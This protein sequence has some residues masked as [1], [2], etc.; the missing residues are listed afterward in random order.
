MKQWW[1]ENT[2][3]FDKKKLFLKVW[4]WIFLFIIFVIFF[5][6]FSFLHDTVQAWKEN[7]IKKIE[8]NNFIEVAFKNNISSYILKLIKDY[9]Q[10]KNVLKEDKFAFLFIE[11]NVQFFLDLLWYG[12]YAD[13]IIYIYKQFKPYKEE[14]FK[15][16]WEDKQKNYLIIFENIWEERPDSWF[17][18]SFAKVS[19]S[20]AHIVDFKIYDSYYL[21]WKY[22][23]TSWN[24]WFDKC[25]NKEELSLKNEIHIFNDLFSTTT[26]LT[27]NIYWFT[28]LNAE[29]IIRHYNQV[30]PEKINWVIF[31]KSSILEYLIPAWKE[32]IRNMEVLNSIKKYSWKYEYNE[33]LKW[34]WWAKTS[35]L[36]YINSFDRKSLI[37]QIIKNYKKITLNWQIR[38]YLSWI[39]VD[40]ENYLK[41]KNL[42]FYKKPYYWYLFFYNLWFNKI[43]KFVDHIV[44]VDDKVYINPDWFLLSKWK[45]IIKYLNLLNIDE[46]YYSFLKEKKISK[47]SYLYD[48]KMNYKTILIV[49]ENCKKESENI[50][51]YV[52]YCE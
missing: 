37:L 49:P 10:W 26:F 23:W 2:K 9:K 34:L 35:Y 18:W 19:F 15:L 40:F 31:F 29:N 51:N 12:D 17:F 11:E 14:I 33:T 36:E 25:K 47:T 38:V 4:K 13:D 46:Q 30:F 16:L 27:A 32:K 52:V 20:W 42:I 5:A 44:V 39:S 3:K 48:K 24:E 1:F 45:H 50:D 28:K 22:C 6:F 43:S 21:L 8:N 7:F 41:Q